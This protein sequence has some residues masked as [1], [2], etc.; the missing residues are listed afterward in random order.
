MGLGMAG[1]VESRRLL[2]ILKANGASMPGFSVW[3]LCSQIHDVIR[4]YLK[5]VEEG[6]FLKGFHYIS[7]LE[8]ANL[9]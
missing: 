3:W 1:G 5:S 8:K 9:S 7:E 6:C 2:E 4:V